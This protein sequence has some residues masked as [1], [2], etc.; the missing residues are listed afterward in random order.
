MKLKHTSPQCT[1]SHI[2]PMCSYSV[3]TKIFYTFLSH[4]FSKPPD[5]TVLLFEAPKLQLFFGHKKTAP[6][7][8]EAS[9]HLPVFVGSFLMLFFPSEAEGLDLAAP[10]FTALGRLGEASTNTHAGVCVIMIG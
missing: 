6:K 2:T 8:P 5:V 3:S 4:S 7:V 1:L 9:S 10:P